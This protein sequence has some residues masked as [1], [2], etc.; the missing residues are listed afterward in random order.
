MRMRRMRN[1]EPRMEKC[2]DYRV[3]DPAA[4]GDPAPAGPAGDPGGADGAPAGGS[5]RLLFPGDDD[6]SDRPDPGCQQKHHQPDSETGGAE[7]A[8]LL[9]ILKC[10]P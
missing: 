6:P 1:L 8:A 7:I 4:P 5:H 10:V 2:A 3:A 9:K